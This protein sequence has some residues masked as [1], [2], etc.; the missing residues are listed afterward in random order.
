M[1]VL[2]NIIIMKYHHIVKMLHHIAFVFMCFVPYT[3]IW[4]ILE[5]ILCK[6]I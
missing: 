6:D 1:M 2:H 5:L 4:N 3:H